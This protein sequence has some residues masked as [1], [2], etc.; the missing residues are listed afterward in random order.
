[1]LSDEMIMYNLAGIKNVYGM[2]VILY[3]CVF[4]IY[5]CQENFIWPASSSASLFLSS[6]LASASCLCAGDGGTGE[7][8]AERGA[9]IA[10]GQGTGRG[11]IGG[12][13]GMIKALVAVMVV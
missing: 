3:R 7:D 11:G 9:G 10:V 4:R 13:P 6:Y 2:L 12:T 8:I 1:M 5:K